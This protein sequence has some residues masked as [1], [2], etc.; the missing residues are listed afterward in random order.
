M[1]SGLREDL[2][3]ALHELRQE[4]VDLSAELQ[5]CRLARWNRVLRSELE[6]E[7]L[8]E[9][10]LELRE[11]LQRAQLEEEYAA[12]HGKLDGLQRSRLSMSVTE[13]DASVSSRDAGPSRASVEVAAPPEL[14][15]DPHGDPSAP[16]GASPANG[17][18][19]TTAATATPPL[20]K[21]RWKSASPSHAT[22]RSAIRLDRP[23]RVPQSS[24]PPANSPRAGRQA[25]EGNQHGQ[26]R[27]PTPPGPTPARGG[28]GS[29][30]SG[31]H[32]S[33]S[34]TP[35]VMPPPPGG[36]A[37]QA[38]AR[39]H[40]GAVGATPR[41]G[42]DQRRLLR[43]QTDA[44]REPRGWPAVPGGRTPAQHSC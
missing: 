5:R 13:L 34:S 9:R 15:R 18:S 22:P 37:A 1:A 27:V 17:A 42:M 43:R 26:H 39:G 35:Q 33:A 29:V 8:L 23:P 38:A 31:T 21:E 2:Q 24:A 40:D 12:L 6:T 28:T 20:M 3:K 19:V 32:S 30:H 7:R 41:T 25:Y 10:N 36:T 11:A 44:C 14:D 4:Q 16:S